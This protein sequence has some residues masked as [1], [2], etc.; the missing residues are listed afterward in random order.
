MRSRLYDAVKNK[1]QVE[2]IETQIIQS[3][4]VMYGGQEDDDEPETEGKDDE[5]GDNWGDNEDD[6]DPTNGSPKN[7]VEEPE[8][9]E[10]ETSAW[11]V[12]DSTPADDQPDQPDDGEE[13]AEN[14]GW[15]D[16]ENE[17]DAV[18]QKPLL[19]T[20]ESAKTTTQSKKSPKKTQPIR[21]EITL[22]ETYTVTLIPDVILDL[23]SQILDDASLLKSPS[24]HMP[25]ISAAA[26]GLS[27]IPTLLL[28]LFRA[29]CPTYYTNDPAGPMLI[30]ND[31][32]HLITSLQSFLSSIPPTHPLASR[33]R[34]DADIEQL[35]AFARRAYGREMD[36]QRTILS[37]ILSSTSGFVNCT[38]PLNAAQY[39]ATV[40]DAAKR[41]RDVDT[42]WKGV[43][44]DSARLQSLGSLVGTLVRQMVSDILER[45]DD[46]VGISEEQSKMLKKFCDRI[47]ALA[48]L[49]NESGPEGDTRSLVHVYT[50]GWLRFVYLG[51][52]LEASLADIRYLWT[53]GE[54]ALEFE[55]DEVIEL[56]QALF[57]ESGFRKDAIRE[58]RRTDGARTAPR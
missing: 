48:D 56:I 29:T 6:K 51:E 20:K 7:T 12:E 46:P 23:L 24:F 38:A 32:Q 31:S 25:I 4:D 47:A 39:D 44:S 2:K 26:P 30:Y 9:E 16:E 15:G 22:R 50:Q 49:F 40:S 35:G 14:W 11:D 3:D 52:I 37:D 36:A 10:D 8:E 1:K 17:G 42:V 33:I 57:A 28:A 54:L 53:E 34:L 43:L 19:P 5:W 41:V 27:S 55:A 58:I 45:A 18:Q 13:E 21:K